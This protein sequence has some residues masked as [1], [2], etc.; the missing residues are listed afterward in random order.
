MKHSVIGWCNSR[1]LPKKKN[2]EPFGLL[3][4]QVGS[5]SHNVGSPHK[6]IHYNIN[7]K[8]MTLDAQ[9][10]TSHTNLNIVLTYSLKHKAANKFFSTSSHFSGHKFLPDK[11]AV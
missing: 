9:V 7:F 6:K 5:L 8:I 3:I 11:K 2:W 10:M 4:G 1:L